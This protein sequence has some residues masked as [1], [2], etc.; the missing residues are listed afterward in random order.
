MKLIRRREKQWI[1]SNKWRTIV[2]DNVRLVE[3]FSN[4]RKQTN[5]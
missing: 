3:T 5:G 1:R 4:V 2:V